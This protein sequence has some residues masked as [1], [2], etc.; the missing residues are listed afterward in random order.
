M[1]FIHVAKDSCSFMFPMP[2][3]NS[4]SSS[5]FSLQDL[6]LQITPSFLQPSLPWLARNHIL[7]IFLL[8]HWLLRFS[9]LCQTQTSDLTSTLS[10]LLLC[11]LNFSHGGNT[12]HILSN[13]RQIV[14][15]F[16]YLEQDASTNGCHHPGS[17]LDLVFLACTVRTWSLLLTLS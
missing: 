7:L 6:T 9:L 12:C 13:L 15:P 8:P 16:T 2:V 1:V 11:D 14:S 4:Q 5:A 3:S 17:S 10:K